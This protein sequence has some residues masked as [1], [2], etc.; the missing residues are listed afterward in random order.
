MKLH[1]LKTH[2]ARQVRNLRSCIKVALDFVAPEHVGHCVRLTEELRLLPEGHYR[3]QVTPRA[4][5]PKRSSHFAR[6]M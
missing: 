1:R 4:T 3:R 2:D 6:W 5:R